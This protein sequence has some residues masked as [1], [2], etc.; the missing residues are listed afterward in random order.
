MI[1]MTTFLAVSYLYPNGQD[2]RPVLADGNCFVQAVKYLYRID[3]PTNVL[4]SIHVFNAVTCCVAICKNQVCRGR[5][6]LM[7]GT[8]VLTALIVLATMFLKQ[9]T[10]VDVALALILYGVCY[11][12][13]YVAQPISKRKSTERGVALRH[14][15]DHFAA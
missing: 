9:H 15:L 12:L 8:V 14:R 11:R 3:T 13:V 7:V 10:V 1:G 2:L 6:P 4:P 5:R